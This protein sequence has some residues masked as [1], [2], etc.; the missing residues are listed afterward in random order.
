MSGKWIAMFLG[1]YIIILVLSTIS[2]GGTVI[3]SPGSQPENQLTYLMNISNAFFSLPILGGIPLPMPNPSYFKALWDTITLQPVRDM[4]DGGGFALFYW[5]V[6]V[7]IICMGVYALVCLFLA[8]I[9][10]NLSWG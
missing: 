10:G 4:F 7:P 8:I 5:I 6:I 9:R 2:G 1:L 3:S